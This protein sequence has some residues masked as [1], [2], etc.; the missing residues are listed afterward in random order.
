MLIPTFIVNFVIQVSVFLI[1]NG[2]PLSKN[3][4]LKEIANNVALLTQQD[5]NKWVIFLLDF[6]KQQSQ[7]ISI[8]IF[9][10][11]SGQTTTSL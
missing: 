5:R 4:Q 9:P 1:C 8:R 10:S 3:G 11:L 6:H 2:G 7:L